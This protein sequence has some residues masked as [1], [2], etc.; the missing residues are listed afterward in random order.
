MFS[1]LLTAA[2][3][4]NVLLLHDGATG[5]TARSVDTT[6]YIIFFLQTGW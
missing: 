3:F 2:S 6:V 1:A 4:M 5:Q